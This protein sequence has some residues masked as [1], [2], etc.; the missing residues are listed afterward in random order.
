MI[1]ISGFCKA[2]DWMNKY[3]GLA[4]SCGADGEFAMGAVHRITCLEGYYARPVE[5]FKMVSELSGSNYYKSDVLKEATSILD[6][7]VM[8]GA[9]DGL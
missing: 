2:D 3:I 4:G 6:V 9:A 5:F 7:I 1:Y 8:I